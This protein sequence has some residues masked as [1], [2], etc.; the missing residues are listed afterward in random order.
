MEMYEPIDGADIGSNS[1]MWI[2]ACWKLQEIRSPVGPLAESRWCSRW[3]PSLLLLHPSSYNRMRGLGAHPLVLTSVFDDVSMGVGGRFVGVWLVTRLLF[4]PCAFF[5]CF[6][7][8]LQIL[9]AAVGPLAES[10]CYFRWARSPRLLHPSSYNRMRG[11]G[12]HPLGLTACLA[13]RAWPSTDVFAV[14]C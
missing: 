12:A 8:I 2:S 10:R 13:V 9:A 6:Q 5:P 4:L 14:R 11:L 3:A 7:T 1:H